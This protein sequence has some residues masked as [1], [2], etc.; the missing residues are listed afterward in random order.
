MPAVILMVVMALSAMSTALDQVRCLDAARAT[1]RLLARGD[2]PERAITQ[3]RALAPPGAELSVRQSGQDLEVR[4]VGHPGPALA[5]LG[6]R[7]T[8]QGSAVAAEED[9]P[10]VTGSTLRPPV[11]P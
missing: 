6:A 1:A 8:P 10:S 4:V 5:W 11:R 2:S 9:D 3:G 7:A